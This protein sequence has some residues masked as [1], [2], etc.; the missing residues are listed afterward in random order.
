M[1]LAGDRRAIEFVDPPAGRRRAIGRHVRELVGSTWHRGETLGIGLH[2]APMAVLDLAAE[3][4]LNISAE[5]RQALLD[6][7]ANHD[8][9][10]LQSVATVGPTVDIDDLGITLLPHQHA[11][12]GYALAHRR[13][14]VADEMGLGKTALSLATA[15]AA[16]ATPVVVACKPDLVENWLA[17]I[18][19][20][21]P[22]RR[23]FTARG[24]TPEPIAPEAEIIVI[25]LAA[26]GAREKPSGGNPERFLWVEQV[27]QQRPEA[28]IVDEGHLGAARSRA[29]AAIGIDVAARDGIILDLTAHRW[30]TGPANWHSSW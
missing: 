17:E 27:L 10:T 14:I 5:A 20:V 29:M 23:V 28:L 16:G 21:L 1:V 24:M 15:A 19:K 26:L 25:G 11:G 8:L 13:L 6:E 30:S 12:V 7:A 2:V 22:G 18:A 4:D 9:N 3:H